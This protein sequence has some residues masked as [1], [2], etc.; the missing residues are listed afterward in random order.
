MDESG[1]A[2]YLQDIGIRAIFSENFSSIRSVL[3][4]PLEHKKNKK[5]KQTDQLLWGNVG[6]SPAITRF[7][8]TYTVRWL[9]CGTYISLI[10]K[11]THSRLPKRPN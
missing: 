7:Y 1:Y 9:G 2:A 8:G 3:V 5:M 4:S 6:A 10:L 11:V